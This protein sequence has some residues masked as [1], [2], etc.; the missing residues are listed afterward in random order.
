[1]REGPECQAEESGMNPSGKEKPGKRAMQ[2]QSHG[3]N[4]GKVSLNH[5]DGGFSG[6]ERPGQGYWLHPAP[7]TGT[8][9]HRIVGAG[10][11]GRQRTLQIEHLHLGW[12]CRHN[13]PHR[14]KRKSSQVSCPPL[15]PQADIY[16]HND[17]LY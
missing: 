9:N 10:G 4:G 3:W 17:S 8:P 11:T 12:V 7:R 1:M 14:S 16:F 15:K 6:V 2:R 5:G 13:Y